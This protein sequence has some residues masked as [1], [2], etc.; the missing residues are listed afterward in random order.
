MNRKIH[1][2]KGTYTALVTPFRDGQ[3][4]WPTVDRLIDRQLDAG[5]D[6]IVPCGSTGESAALTGA[7]HQRLVE[8]VIRRVDGRCKVIAGTGS[9][10]TAHAIDL[11]QRAASAGADGALVVT[12]YYNRPTQ[13]GL[14]RHYAAVAD[15]TSIP[16]ILYNVP[17]RCAV[18][19]QNE[20]ILR[21]ADRCENIVAVKDASGGV[22]RVSELAAHPRLTVL[23]GDDSLTLPMMSLGAVG[24]ISVISNLVPAWMKSLVDAVPSDP[25]AARNWHARAC[26]LADDIGR[27]GPNP[28]PI[29]TA[30]ALQGLLAEE[31]RLPLCPMGDEQRRHIQ[32]SLSQSLGREKEFA[33][34]NKKPSPQVE[35]VGAR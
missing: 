26:G 3:I 28:L 2:W 11:T 22:G 17:A 30:M 10:S 16:I 4:D 24:V 14:F 15:S 32:A 19:L 9:S 5:I 33:V 1:S 21:L 34:E 25:L 27:W 7:E 20:T 35:A 31:F 12:P 8:A 6:G 18:D 13:E 23:C 29:K